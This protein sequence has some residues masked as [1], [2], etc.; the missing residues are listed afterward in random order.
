MTQAMF[1]SMFIAAFGTVLGIIT[2]WFWKSRDAAVQKAKAIEIEHQ[3]AL[4]RLDALEKKQGIVDAQL[5]PFN[6]LMQAMLIKELT[7]AH[8]PEMDA[9]MTKIGPPNTL[10]TT[11]EARLAVLL[12]ERYERLDD[13][14]PERERDAAFILPAIIRRARDEAQ[15]LTDADAMRLKLV[16]IAA[17]VAV[18]IT[19][20]EP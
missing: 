10:T 20:G 5:V 1:N 13:T 8:T 9:L 16:S 19:S 6:G 17:V 14:V 4:A 18:P 2:T 15:I 12:K 7:H 3:K 11:E